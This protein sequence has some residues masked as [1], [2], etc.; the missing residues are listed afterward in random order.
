MMQQ[1]ISALSIKAV[2]VFHDNLPAV[3]FLE[4]WRPELTELNTVG[5]L[6]PP[7]PPL[8][9]RATTPGRLMQ[10]K[11]R[12]KKWWQ[13]TGGLFIITSAAVHWVMPSFT[14]LH[15]WIHHSVG[16]MT[17]AHSRTFSIT[18]ECSVANTM[19]APRGQP[20]SIIWKRTWFSFSAVEPQFNHELMSQRLFSPLFTVSGMTVRHCPREL[21]SIDWTALPHLRDARR[22]Q[23]ICRQPS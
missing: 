4:G 20:S 18:F 5:G 7:L 11:V 16:T 2:Q 14:H 8:T 17:G 21:Q 3:A 12:L 9:T 15:S 23:R 6:T 19:A 10:L 1:H 13:N 22:S